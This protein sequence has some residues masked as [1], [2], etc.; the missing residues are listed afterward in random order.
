MRL[1]ISGALV[2]LLVPRPALAQPQNPPPLTLA[3][4]LERAMAS[5]PAILAAQGRRAIGAAG[6]AVAGER[7]NPEGRVEL[8]R[9]TPRQAYTLAVPL[10]LGG[11]RSRRLAVAEA[12]VRTA[13]AE[14]A[15]VIAE[16]RNAVRRAYFDRA[17]AEARFALFEDLQAITTRVRDAAQQRFDAGDAP[18]L[19]VL[20]A[21]LALAQAENQVTG[22]RGTAVAAR[23]QFNTLLGLPID[24]QTTL[25]PP[26]LEAPMT[27]EAALARAKTASAELTVIDRRLD[28]QRARVALAK[29]LRTPDLT[30]E[31]SVTRG[32]GEGAEFQT[33]WKAAVAVTMPLFTSHKAGVVLEESTLSQLTAERTAAEARIASEVAAATAI[34]DAQRQQYL[35]YRDQIVPQAIQVENLAN[36][37]Y[38]LGQTGIAAYLLA[39]QATRDVRLAALQAEAELQTA[40]TDLEKAIGAPLE[41]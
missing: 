19:E 6:V 25:A 3:A 8:D 13:D 37:A 26:A 20:Q 1:L 27:Y 30:P 5:N 35:R 15:Q 34:A 4:A 33:G 22:A 29:A 40:L 17:V 18:R 41:R 21:E 24:A 31:G 38:R 23:M 16:T 32:F 2:V 11:K 36:D 9:D 10:E 7:L 14:I 39:L 28:E 12:A